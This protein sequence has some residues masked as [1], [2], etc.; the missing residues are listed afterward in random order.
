MLAVDEL[1]VRFG[2]VDALDKV[3]VELNTAFSGVVGPNGAGKSTFLNCISGLGKLQGGTIRGSIK[4]DGTDLLKCPA[5]E[6]TNLGIGRSFQHPLIVPTL[7]VMEHLTV[8]SMKLRGSQRRQ[9]IEEIVTLVGLGKW[10]TKRAEDLPYGIRKLVDLGRALI[11][12]DRMLLSDEPLSGLD[13]S[14]REAMINLLRDIA[15]LGTRLVVVEH[16]FPR[17]SRVASEILV[18]DLGRVLSIGSATDIRSQQS[19][20]AAFLGEAV[21]TYSESKE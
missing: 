15:S 16:D 19:V 8:A 18:L 11:N 6:R 20:I 3:S 7:T 1:T 12:A 4:F 9:R 17:L 2:G 21:T 5:S 10:M 14:A 13:E